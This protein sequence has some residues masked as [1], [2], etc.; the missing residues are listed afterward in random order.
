MENFKVGDEILYLTKKDIEK[1]NLSMKDIIDIIEEAFIEKAYNRYEMPPK[2]GI[3]TMPDAFIHAMPCWF[4]K[5]KACGIKWVSGY[6]GNN[7]QGYSYINGLLVLNCIETGLPL[8]VMDCVWITAKRTGAVTGLVAKY[9]ARPGSEVIGILGCGVQGRNNL[10]AL[11]VTCPNIKRIYAFDIIAE[12]AKKYSKEMENKF[13][14]EVIPVATQKEAV[15]RSDIIVT[16]AAFSR[17]QVIEAEWFKEGALG[18]PVDV[19]ALWKPEAFHLA[20]KYYVDD[21][22]QYK[23]FQSLGHCTDAPKIYGDIGKLVTQQIKGRENDSERIISVNIGL[24]LEDIAVAQEVYAK[25][26]E[27]NIGSIIPL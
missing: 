7:K 17:K 9:L 19:D 26:I 20:D 6:P 15:V 24:A 12:N 10:E 11:L 22:E 5:H 23:Y 14:I 13:N 18:C 16:T 21:V 25:A 2:I 1:I 8:S 3:H 4:P 27:T